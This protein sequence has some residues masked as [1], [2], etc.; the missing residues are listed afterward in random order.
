MERW[1]AEQRVV[2]IHRDEEL[3]PDAGGAE[4]S[5]KWD[6]WDVDLT[7]KYENAEQA[8]NTALRVHSFARIQRFTKGEWG[9]SLDITFDNI[10][11]RLER[12]RHNKF[13]H[14][15]FGASISR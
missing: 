13:K 10:L 2:G 3:I 6:Y 11:H 8:G 5:T 12:D 1:R 15:C 7:A 4:I 14:N 9:K